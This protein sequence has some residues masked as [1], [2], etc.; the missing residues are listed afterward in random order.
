MS[1]TLDQSNF[2]EFAQKAIAAYD[3]KGMIVDEMLWAGIIGQYDAEAERLRSAL[4]KLYQAVKNSPELR[5]SKLHGL[6]N[7]ALDGEP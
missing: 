6:V 3:K 1:D 5:H 7:R 2:R 4:T